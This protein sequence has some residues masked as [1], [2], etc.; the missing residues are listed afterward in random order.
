MLDSIDCSFVWWCSASLP[1]RLLFIETNRK[2]KEGG[3]L[4]RSHSISFTIPNSPSLD[5]VVPVHLICSF[6]GRQTSSYI[7]H[8]FIAIIICTQAQRSNSWRFSFEKLQRCVEA[9][10]V[11]D[12]KRQSWH[13]SYYHTRNPRS[14][15]H[16]A[17]K[18]QQ[19]HSRIAKEKE[20][21][22]ARKKQAFLV[23]WAGRSKFSTIFSSIICQSTNHVKSTPSSFKSQFPTNNPP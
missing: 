17:R 6:L 9:S 2:N 11:V 16:P 19:A 8:S 7:I 5:Q 10:Q 3:F 12:F 18:N 15:N 21:E 4:L 1:L 20:R 14:L 22:K 13:P 23:V